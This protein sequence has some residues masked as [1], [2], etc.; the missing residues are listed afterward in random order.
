MLCCDT[1]TAALFTNFK[2]LKKGE[3]GWGAGD[4]LIRGGSLKKKLIDWRKNASH[5]FSSGCGLAEGIKQW[6]VS[7]KK[8]I[9]V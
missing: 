1:D 8:Y 5:S 7:I 6:H 3:W 4:G 9:C 2:G